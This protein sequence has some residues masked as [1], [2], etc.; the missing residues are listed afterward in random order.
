M[1]IINN[2]LQVAK[3]KL[4]FI[5]SFFAG[6]GFLIPLFVVNFVSSE[7]YVM[8]AFGILLILFVIYLFL[9]EPEYIYFAEIKGN[10][11]IKN[12][13]ARPIL[14]KYKAYEIKLN[15]LHHFEI[16]RSVFNKKVSIVLWVKTKKGVGN[17]PPLSLSALTKNEQLK[18]TKYL[19]KH[20]IERG[21]NIIP[22]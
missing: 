10:L 7:H 19:S 9:I 2:Q 17:F 13:P 8:F 11:Q 18:L 15:S 22:F 5:L 21:K 6:I 20:S 12:Y 16:K 14:R 3:N 4:A 1:V